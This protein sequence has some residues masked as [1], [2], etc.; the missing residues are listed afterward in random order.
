M[1]V[2]WDSFPAAHAAQ[3]SEPVEMAKRPAGHIKQALKL[4]YPAE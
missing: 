4:A 3:V 2:G 1:R